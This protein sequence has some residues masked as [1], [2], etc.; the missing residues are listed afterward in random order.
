MISYVPNYEPVNRPSICKVF[1]ASSGETFHTAMNYS[2]DSEREEMTSELIYQHLENCVK[3]IADKAHELVLI[4]AGESIG[5]EPNPV[6]GWT[7]LEWANNE[8]NLWFMYVYY[9]AEGSL[10]ESAALDFVIE[11]N[12]EETVDNHTHDGS[13]D[14]THDPETGEEI[15]NA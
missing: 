15:P 3:Y 13:E 11:G 9:K 10:P 8:I 14:H 12:L 1:T 4:K 6:K 7:E 5:S 2:N